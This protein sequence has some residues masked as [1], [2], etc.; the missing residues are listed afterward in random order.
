MYQRFPL[1]A[2]VLAW[3]LATLTIGCGSPITQNSFQ[4]GSPTTSESPAS[5]SSSFSI[6]LLPA[7]PTVTTG[8]GISFT[9]PF[10]GDVVWKV[11][12]VQ[13]GDSIHGTIDTAGNYTSPAV[14]LADAV[15]VSAQLGAFPSSPTASAA[16][17]VM[18]P[19]PRLDFLSPT[20]AFAGTVTPALIV[21]GASFSLNSQILLSGQPIPTTY[22]D[23]GHLSA[24]L[25]DTLMQVPGGSAVSIFT[26]SPGGGTSTQQMITILPAGQV[27]TTS[28][29][30]VAAYGVTIPDKSTVSVDFGLD[31]NYGLQTSK[32]RAPSGGGTVR[33][34]VAGMK[35]SS[36]YH[37][38]AAIHLSDGSTAYDS[39]HLFTIG[40]LP[41]GIVFPSITTQ[42]FAG[43]VPMSGV[44][45]LNL[46]T[47]SEVV[48][49]AT[50]LNGNYVWYY[51]TSSNRGYVDQPAKLLP[52]GHFLTQFND[53][54]VAVAD[55][56]GSV[57]REID[58]EGN[59]IWQMTATDLNN[60][61]AAAGYAITIV[62]THHDCAV[63]PNGHLILLA[64]LAKPFDNLVGFPGTTTVTGD[65]VID[66][67]ANRKPVWVWSA[68][69]HLDINRH[70]IFFPDWTHTNAVLYSPDD[71]NLIISVR[72]QNWIVKIDYRDG[73]GTGDVLWKLGWQGDFQLVGG[74]DPV[75]W[76]FAQHA[77]HFASTNTAG[78]FDL[79]LFD[80]G[81]N[82][83]LDS[84]GNICSTIVPC[85]TTVPMFHIDEQQKTATIL[86]RDRLGIF[87]NFGGY[88]QN[89]DNGDIEFAESA[90]NRPS[91]SSVVQEVTRT[92]PPQPVWQMQI[93]GSNAYRALRIPSLYPGVMWP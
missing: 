87:S 68:F 77:P 83:V 5:P 28:N 35:P 40:G 93:D 31:A 91:V 60:A 53:Y 79:L 57:V 76:F 11:N 47:P 38:R 32:L 71:G 69:D 42:T 6:T 80:N 36:D 56:A 73:L 8:Q 88:V 46:A 29:S 49:A 21:S 48:L 86:W 54:S 37:M 25:P 92:S 17:S 78:N 70:P 44:E 24:S 51:D 3:L 43:Q 12:G 27:A 30:L 52:N 59:T 26:P 58:L 74:T 39:D 90:P 41:S 67:D 84:N 82:R 16:V 55:G 66:L 34:L 61:L 62:G 15:S 7:A 85:E 50:D 65:V 63:L 75:D 64:A 19:A 23:A 4:N 81:N 22:I 14:A 18:N 9:A 2:A 89:F 1:L 20:V 10:V 72:H 33:V 13:G 45:L